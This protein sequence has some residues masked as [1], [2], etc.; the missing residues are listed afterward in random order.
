MKCHLIRSLFLLSVS[1]LSS[2]V[3]AQ[4]L[5]SF[6]VGY[7]QT[8]GDY[9]LVNETEITTIPLNLQYINEAWRLKLT[10][11]FISV[12]GDGS[13]IP[14]SNGVIGVDFNSLIGG[15]LGGGSN[16]SSAIETQSGLGDIVSSLSYAFIPTGDVAWFHELSAEVKWG[17]AN[18][19]KFLG[20]GEN[21]YSLSIYSL[22][23]RN[24]LKPFMSLGYLF[25]GDTPSTDFNNVLFA[26]TGVMYPIN[27]SLLLNVVYDYQQAT[28]DGIDAGQT[29]SLYLTKT[30][31]EGWSTSLYLLNGLSDSVADTG[32]GLSVSRNF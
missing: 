11:P 20:T 1:V 21:D 5:L 30:L 14:G 3:V 29:I 12:S 13:V 22:Y 8:S 15:G 31:N 26:S 4:S 23:E 32:L 17:T 27:G 7:E 24:T 19:N 6:S 28:L 2:N 10:V 9:G 18:E 25:M 16:A